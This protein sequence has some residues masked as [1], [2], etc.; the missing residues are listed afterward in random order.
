MADGSPSALS[1]TSAESPLQSFS[2]WSLASIRNALSPQSTL[3]PSAWDEFKSEERGLWLIQLLLACANHVSCGNMEK[4]NMCLEQLSLL[5]S[6][7]GDSMQRVA[8]YFMEGLAARIT[9][10][11]P[12]LYKAL[13]STHLPSP[14]DLATARQLFFNLCPY[15]KFGFIVVNQSIVEAMEGEE[16]VHIIDLNAAEP[17]QWVALIQALGARHGPGQRPPHLRITGIHEHKEILD[18]TAQ[19][20]TEEAEKLD[21]PFQFHPVVTKLEN[22]DEEMLRVKT[23]EAVA[24]SSVLQLHLLLAADE[25][26]QEIRPGTPLGSLTRLSHGLERPPRISGAAERPPRHP[27]VN[28]VVHR[29]GSGAGHVAYYP[30]SVSSLEELLERERV[31]N[32]IASVSPSHIEAAISRRAAM[33]ELPHVIHAGNR[34]AKLERCLGMLRRLSPKVMVVVEQESN[35]NGAILMERLVEAMHYYGAVFDSLASTLPPQCSMEH[36]VLEKLL[37]GEQIKNIVA[38]E[39]AE[40]KERH[41]KLQGWINRVEM[42]GFGGVP[43]SYESVLQAKSLV[44]RHA[45][46]VLHDQGCITLCWQDRPLFSVSAWRSC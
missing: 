7:T 37:F 21:I 15:L 19:R 5:V 33:V 20:L 6:P 36:L 11:W 40:R 9:K 29:N 31:E 24:I 28:T 23:G 22:L 12:G 2:A 30:V 45:Y 35:H 25:Q 16:F 26:E 14:A 41:E 34:A 1:Q 32:G 38:C 18:Q 8:T 4:T 46:R 44:E 10:S 39:G 13:N 42:G 27:S 3:H 43:L 17:L